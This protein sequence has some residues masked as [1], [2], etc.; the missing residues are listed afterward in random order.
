MGILLA[1]SGPSAVRGVTIPSV[2]AQYC[3][4]RKM[5]GQLIG[6]PLIRSCSTGI[7]NGTQPRCA[8]TTAN[9]P[10]PTKQP[11]TSGNNSTTII[12]L[13]MGALL[14]I[15]IAVVVVLVIVIVVLM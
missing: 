4:V 9:V 5:V 15:V 1:R 10:L 12:G 13:S 2:V 6:V 8:P 11:I 3:C 7:W 14:L